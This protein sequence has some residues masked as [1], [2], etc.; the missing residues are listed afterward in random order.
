M[1]SPT[2][3]FGFQ[4][5]AIEELQPLFPAYEILGFIAQG[6][7]GAVYFANQTSLDR[8]VA[9]KILPRQFG[10]DPQFRAGFEAEAKAMARLNHPNLIGVYDFG[11]VDGFLFIIMEMV[12]G[13]SL[14]HSA[15]GRM[16]E[17]KEAARI[18]AGICHGLA[19]AHLQGILHRDIKPAN[20]L[21]SP[22]ATP[23]IG[24]FGLARP[25]GEEHNPDEIVFGTPGYSAPE[26]INHPEAVDQR[27]DIF[28]VGALLY[29]L[30]TGQLPGDPYKPPSQLAGCDADFDS[31]VR[32]ATHPSP[33]MR[34]DDA[35]AIADDLEKVIKKLEGGVLRRANPAF[36]AVGAAPVAA[37]AV[38]PGPVHR[39]SNTRPVVIVALLIGIV[40]MGALIAVNS[41]K[42]DPPAPQV[43][44]NLP[45]PEP[46]P[47]LDR[48]LKPKQPPAMVD[49]GSS[50]DNPRRDNGTKPTDPE[51]VVPESTSESLARLQDNLKKGN[52]DE[53]PPGTVQHEDS[54]LL[55]VKGALTWPQA[56]QFAEAHGAQLAVLATSGDLAWA[57][58]QFK[59]TAL[60][61]LGLSDSG[62]EEKWHWVS[63]AAATKDVWA[64]GQPDNTTSPDDGED[65]AALLPSV[66]QIDDLPGS[67]QL[68]FLLQWSTK[69]PNEGSIRNQLARTGLALRE[70]RS[71]VFPAGTRNINGS[72]FL[73]VPQRASWDEA[74]VI[75]TAAGGHLAVPSSQAEASWIID[76]FRAR[77]D[78]GDCCWVGGLQ[79]GPPSPRW[80]FV[81][82]EIFE[83]VE[84]AAQQPD[85]TV[86]RQPCLQISRSAEKGDTFGYSSAP[87]TSKSTAGFLLEW[88][89]PSRRNM[90]NDEEKNAPDTAEAWLIA[91]RQ[92]TSAA[93]Q[94]GYKSF[95]R[96]WER[97]VEDF[98]EAI[99]STADFTRGRRAN[100]FEKIAKDFAGS[101]EKDGRIPEEIPRTVERLVGD[102]HEK[103]LEKQ[104]KI[105]EG[106]KPEFEEAL[107][108]YLSAISGQV[109]RLTQL[110]DRDGTGYL[111]REFK[112]ASNDQ[113]RFRSILNGESP[114]VP[115]GDTEPE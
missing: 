42:N 17:P 40:V 14:F 56:Q 2:H 92:K 88:S 83:F 37:K 66:S 35:A 114:P 80:T 78:E 23:K 109:K 85:E 99:Q 45:L 26:V 18:V 31:V 95:K 1:E 20:I 38:H 33:S 61:W 54:H 65:F 27:A 104:N 11:E 32:R 76:T 53:M 108:G 13:K 101:I 12:D 100:P 75:A 6:G 9:I 48:P 3:D 72:R 7:M 98:S 90:P 107:E 67:R 24:D 59:A 93:E 68:P 28:S 44:E 41:G 94:V 82:G 4:A 71:P 63:G 113:E 50:P 5:P 84:W 97:N 79:T 51:P 110:G 15:H 70:K 16:I 87:A 86:V 47:E 60:L 46:A 25:V 74:S 21:L 112:A 105:W 19:D 30:L 81:T 106:Y 69:G 36:A 29:E 89:A 39:K 55:L 73:W 34:Y 96:R 111:E 77:L 103:A 22:E 43:D 91:L 8:P 10:A 102:L 52:F 58:S 64:P 115:E 57:S 49:G 62:T